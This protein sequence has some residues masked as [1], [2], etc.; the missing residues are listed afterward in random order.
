MSPHVP[1][2]TENM[3]Q[4]MRKCINGQSKQFQDSI[5]H[6]YIPTVNEEFKNKQIEEGMQAVISIIETGRK[7]RE[8]KNISL[9]QPIM[10][11]TIVSG[12]EVLM[13]E[14]KPFLG[15]V[16][17]ELNVAE[18]DFEAQV[19]KYV[20]MTCLPNLPV[21]GPKFKGNKA[22]GD[23]K[24]GITS[25]KND[26]IKAAKAKGEIEIAGHNLKTAED[27]IVQEKYVPNSV[28]E[29]EVIGGDKVVILLDTRQDEKL[30]IRGF[31]REII[32]R[33]QK[34][35]KKTGLSAEDEVFIFYH[36]PAESTQLNKAI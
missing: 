16:E 4:N 7:L 15:Y 2:V 12:D 6:L 29:Y 13:G 30:K 35:K 25:L 11:L 18:I 8:Q 10:K 21:L 28:K 9:K 19:E 27:L 24:K 3:Y 5:H 36:F 1:F 26:Q 23:V 33:I 32:N 34:L 22:F 31:A 17:E 20:E 14:L